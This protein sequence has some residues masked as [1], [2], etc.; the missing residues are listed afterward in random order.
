MPPLIDQVFSQSQ[1]DAIRSLWEDKNV[2]L[3]LQKEIGKQLL[4]DTKLIDETPLTQL[5]FL[6]SLSSFSS[7]DQECYYVASIIWWGLNEEDILPRVAEHRGKDLAYRCLISLGFF[8][9]ALISKWERHA[10]PSPSFYRDVGMRSFDQ[11][12]MPNVSHH[13]RQWEHFM[14]EF[15]V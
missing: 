14:G 8:K 2:R 7:S 9:N 13:F 4:L 3:L 12:G 5:M 10:A 6:T 11:I 1:A 15:F